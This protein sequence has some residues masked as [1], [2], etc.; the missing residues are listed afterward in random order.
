M[1][2]GGLDEIYAPSSMDDHDVCYRAYEQHGWVAGAYW[3]DYI[4]QSFWST[5]RSDN[6]LLTPKWFYKA[7][8]KNS[9]IIL[10][11]HKELILGEHHD[12]NRELV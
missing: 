11:R 10:N 9:K 1:Q 3:I 6:P 4:S 12:E 7:H 2:L 5:T 8:H